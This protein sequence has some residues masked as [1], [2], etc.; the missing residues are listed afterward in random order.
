MLPFDDGVGKLAGDSGALFGSGDLIP[1][2]VL[3]G[4]LALS[5]T[6]AYVAGAGRSGRGAHRSARR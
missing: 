2:L 6:I 5:A 3:G 4:L 1:T